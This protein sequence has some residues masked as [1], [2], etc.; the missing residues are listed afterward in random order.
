MRLIATSHGKGPGDGIGGVVKKL[1]ARHSKQLVKSGKEKLLS[2]EQLYKYARE[3][4][5]GWGCSM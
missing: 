2:V 1:A 3:N 5:A 4:I